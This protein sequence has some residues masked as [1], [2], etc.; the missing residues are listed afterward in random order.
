ML[1]ILATSKI[2]DFELLSCSPEL[3]IDFE[4]NR[5]IVTRPIKGTMPRYADPK[6]R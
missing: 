3:F 6:Q 4:A 2:D 1:P 5:K